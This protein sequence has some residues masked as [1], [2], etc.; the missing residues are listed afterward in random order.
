[1][2]KSYCR[3]WR[4]RLPHGRAEVVVGNGEQEHGIAVLTTVFGK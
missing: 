4:H 1:M 2:S 3:F